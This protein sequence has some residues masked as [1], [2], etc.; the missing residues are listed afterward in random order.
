[1]SPCWHRPPQGPWSLLACVVWVPRIDVRKP[2][3]VIN[4]K[5]G[6]PL[7]GAPAKP[8]SCRY[9]RR[10]DNTPR[11]SWPGSGSSACTPWLCSAAPRPRTGRRCSRPPSTAPRG[12]AACCSPSSWP[13]CCPSTVAPRLQRGEGRRR[14]RRGAGGAH[15]LS[16]QSWAN[17]NGISFW[18]H[19]VSYTHSFNKPVSR[20]PGEHKRR[21]VTR[22]MDGR[23]R[24][25]LCCCWWYMVTAN[26]EELLSASCCSP[27]SPAILWLRA[28]EWFIWVSAVTTGV[29]VRVSVWYHKF[30]PK[31]LCFDR[32]SLWSWVGTIKSE[33]I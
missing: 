6:A 22:S 5:D 20:K 23:L 29:N 18:S 1:M 28:V 17:L 19:N 33:A 12:P 4:L 30:H 32:Q 10:K 8:P 9:L 26:S 2:F 7:W 13:S 24:P 31:A 16:S 21:R 3:S 27:R 11:G 14:V 15:S 25:L